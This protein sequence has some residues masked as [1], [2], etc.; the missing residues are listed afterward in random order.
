MA[1]HS[2]TEFIE[3]LETDNELVRIKEPVSPIL[4]IAEIT[5]RVSKQSG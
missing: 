1:Y 5:D 3:Q 4:E 2:L